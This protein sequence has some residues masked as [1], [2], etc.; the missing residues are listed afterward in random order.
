MREA[1]IQKLKDLGF[2]RVQKMK[3]GSTHYGKQMAY[4]L[5]VITDLLTYYISV[6]NDIIGRKELETLVAYDRWINET[7]NVLVTL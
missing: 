7:L 2:T 6:P 4:G 3:D 1:Q 5:I